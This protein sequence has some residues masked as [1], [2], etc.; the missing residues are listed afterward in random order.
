MNRRIFNS[1]ILPAAALAVFS[2]IAFGGWLE[3]TTAAIAT[4]ETEY[5]GLK[6]GITYELKDS[7][8][9]ADSP[10]WVF[11]RWSADSGRTWKLLPERFATGDGLG[12][13][14]SSG[15]KSID[16]WGT[17]EIGPA[18]A[19]S[20]IV[21]VRAIAVARIPAGE[22]VM[23]S[24][25]GGGYDSGRIGQTVSTL[26]L[27]YLAK[28]ETT[29]DMY[30]DYLNETG[31]DGRGWN[32]Q[33][34]DSARCGIERL[35]GEGGFVYRVAGGR[36]NFPVNFVSWY[37][38]TGFLAWCGL[39]LPSEAQ[40]E[41]AWRGGKFIDGDSIMQKPN[42]LP[43]RKFPWGDEE[44][45]AGG[46][47]RCNWRGAE[48][49]FVDLA[50]VGSFPAYA[51]PYG[52]CDLAG[53]V[54]EWTVDFYATTYHAGLDGYRMSRGGSWR[55]FPSG[56]DAISGATNLPLSESGIMGFRGV[57]GQ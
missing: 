9:T 18:S 28:Y 36:E 39:A 37:D 2:G 3:V 5:A 11:V 29:I 32:P 33:M 4:V 35:E 57:Y 40:W 56:V 12:I 48:D 51:S 24:T 15:K 31:G 8:V 52:I 50:P 13:V 14:E 20:L 30:T 34:A 19:D 44:P 27:Y 38:A 55:S 42:P 41:K 46:V 10:A 22:F 23:K 16:W 25:P 1:V 43:E 47:F 26:P 45:G 7:S 6:V 53:N 21:T 49:G 54:S 17:D